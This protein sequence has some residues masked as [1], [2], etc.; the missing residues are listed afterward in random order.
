MEIPLDDTYTSSANGGHLRGV[1][2]CLRRYTD[3]DLN[4]KSIYS[5]SLTED[6][7]IWGDTESLDSGGL[8]K[9]LG[10]GRITGDWGPL[11]LTEA[12][13]NG[14][15]WWPTL[16]VEAAEANLLL[17]PLPLPPPPVRFWFDVGKC[18]VVCSQEAKCRVVVV[19]APVP[20]W[21]ERKIV[22]N[23]MIPRYKHIYSCK[24]LQFFPSYNFCNLSFQTVAHVTGLSIFHF[25]LYVCRLSKYISIVLKAMAVTSCK[26]SR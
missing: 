4:F 11:R 1:G 22:Y 5:P 7:K 3:L 2:G 19:L 12:A 25:R 16:P 20:V 8:A 15:V 26:L 10:I 23:Q 9:R 6:G 24:P 17:P 18:V 14:W 21:N 13:S